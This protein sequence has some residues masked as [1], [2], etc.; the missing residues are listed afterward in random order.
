[1]NRNFGLDISRVTAIL[2]VLICHGLSWF[3]L[4]YGVLGFVYVFGYLGVEIF[5][6][7]SGFLIGSILIRDI[8]HSGSWNSLPNFYVRRWLR[9][10][11]V[12]YF[13]ILILYILDSS[14]FNLETMLF[15][16]NFEA[17]KL[18][19]FP[20][21]WSLS[22][23]EWFYLLCPIVFLLI[24]KLSNSN[25]KVLIFSNLFILL[26]INILRI[27]YVINYDPSWDQ[28]VR[29][30]IPIR[31]DSL[32]IGVLLASVKF[33]WVKF[34]T[35]VARGKIYL[36]ASLIILYYFG[37]QFVYDGITQNTI[38]NSFYSRTLL[39]FV[40]SLSCAV[41]IAYFEQSKVNRTSSSVFRKVITFLSKI[42]YSIYLVH[43]PIFK[44]LSVV[45]ESHNSIVV[46]FSLLFCSLILTLIIA[47]VLYYC[48]EIPFLKLRDKYVPARKISL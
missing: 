47:T 6:V 19:F 1:M 36:I 32:L 17:E 12:Y 27:V 41:I 26:F 7:L 10:I 2:M 30:Q 9:T 38:N 34:Y 43:F 37:M 39:F 28:G 16:Q 46:K 45:L 44:F 15:L 40:V 13:V 4:D 18:L 22:I 11:P 35:K 25:K 8:F 23:E 14:Q 48:I 42:S 29:K 31:L 33:Y 24:S 20:V 21:S 3:F 5:F